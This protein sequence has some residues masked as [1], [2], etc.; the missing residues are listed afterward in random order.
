MTGGVPPE[1]VLFESSRAGRRASTI[2]ATGISRSGARDRLPAGLTSATA[3]QLPELSE[4]DIV[5]HYTRLAHRNF[6][7]DEGFYPLGSCTMK[8]NP[9]IAEVVAALPG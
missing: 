8:Y 7:I 9:K 6:S 1:P 3:P 5:R 4:R 2:P